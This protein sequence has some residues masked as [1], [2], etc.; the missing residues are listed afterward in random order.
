MKL[1]LEYFKRDS[2][3]VELEIK[4]IVTELNNDL[5]KTR[6]LLIKMRNDL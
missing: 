1:L 3:A 6:N 5:R 2:I 4:E